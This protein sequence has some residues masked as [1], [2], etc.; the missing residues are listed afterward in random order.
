M[1]KKVDHFIENERNAT[2]VPLIREQD[3]REIKEA[4]E[5]GGA[6]EYILT[7]TIKQI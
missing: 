2:R 4:Y 3:M 7:R 6:F 5:I 1:F